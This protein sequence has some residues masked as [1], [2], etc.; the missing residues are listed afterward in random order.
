M[1]SACGQLAA[2]L[3]LVL[4]LVVLVVVAVQ[5]QWRRHLL[6]RDGSDGQQFE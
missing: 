6:Q 3:V 5:W 1:T 4:L 2:L